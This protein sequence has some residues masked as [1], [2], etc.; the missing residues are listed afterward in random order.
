MEGPIVHSWFI[1]DE[2]EDDKDPIEIWHEFQHYML[3]FYPLQ[4]LIAT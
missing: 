1:R 2:E 3:P 4:F